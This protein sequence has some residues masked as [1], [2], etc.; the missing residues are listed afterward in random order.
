MN[1]L[2][3]YRIS[4]KGNPEKLKPDYV[5]KETCLRNF[6]DVFTND[7][8]VVI[9]DNVVKQTYEMVK[10]YVP[11]NNILLS[12]R[13]NTGTF[14]ASWELAYELV[15]NNFGNVIVYFVE[16]DYIHRKN[17]KQ[18]LLEAFT[19]LDAEYVTLYDHPD[20]YQNNKDPRFKWGHFK[21]D[22]DVD[23]IRKPGIIYKHPTSCDLYVSTSSHW[24]T[25]SSTTMTFATTGK[26]IVEDFQ[27]MIN[28]HNG[29]KLPMGGDT[30]KLLKGKGK[31]L[32][33]PIPS[34]SAHGEERWLPY[35]I[36][37]EKE[38]EK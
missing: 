24:R 12:N 6:V 5:T 4:D 20:K 25:V 2:N 7:N 14:L 27:D 17:S 18:I 33:S 8:L 36:N 21:V 22:K 30:F 23:G 1:L 10:K 19:D 37:W 11:E 28:L 3:I 34:Y 38:I 32:I 26:N 29:K 35:F 13:G 16:D 9:C 31:E 15:K